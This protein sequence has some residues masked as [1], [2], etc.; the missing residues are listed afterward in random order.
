MTDFYEPRLKYDFE[1]GV[2]SLFDEM[3]NNAEDILMTF[4]EGHMESLKII[5]FIV[6]DEETAEAAAIIK[7]GRDDLFEADVLQDALG[8]VI[9]AYADA[10]YELNK[11]RQAMMADT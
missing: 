11:L 5:G 9:K 6:A 2:R 10:V 4:C 7:R 3:A 1:E 8:D